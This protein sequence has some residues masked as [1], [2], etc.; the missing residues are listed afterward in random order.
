MDLPSPEKSG[1]NEAM[2]DVPQQPSRGY[3]CDGLF[4]RPNAHFLVCCTAFSSSATTGVRSC[5][6]M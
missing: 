4:H 6:S 5:T 2:A 1:P 3:C